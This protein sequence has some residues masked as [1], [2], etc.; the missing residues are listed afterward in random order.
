MK[1]TLVKIGEVNLEKVEIT[2]DALKENIPKAKALRK[3]IPIPPGSYS[4]R[5]DQYNSPEILGR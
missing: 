2:T 5:R 1:I 3:I 4:K